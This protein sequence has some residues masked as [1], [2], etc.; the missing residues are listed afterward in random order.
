MAD[1]D[2]EEFQERLAYTFSQMDPNKT[3]A[4]NHMQLRKWISAQMKDDE[5]V[6]SSGITDEMQEASTD[7]FAKYKRQS[8]DM[9]GVA[10][11]AELLRELDLLKYMPEDVP[12]PEPEPVQEGLSAEE[13]TE[14]LEAANAEIHDLKHDLKVS[15]REAKKAKA[16]LEDVEEEVEEVTAEKEEAQG[17]VKN[18]RRRWRRRRKR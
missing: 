13:L 2:D 9:L 10:E 5:Q 15:K 6:E 17:K 7:A 8:D 4:V 14:M 1:E 18:S 3:G 16:E 11:V 12:E